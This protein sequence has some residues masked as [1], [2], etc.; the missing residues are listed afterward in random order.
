MGAPVFFEDFAEFES[1][2]M[3]SRKALLL[4]AFLSAFEYCSSY[5]LIYCN[6]AKYQIGIEGEKDLSMRLGKVHFCVPKTLLIPVRHL[7]RLS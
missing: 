5:Q 4:V 1:G 3:E 7:D 2:Q 6:V